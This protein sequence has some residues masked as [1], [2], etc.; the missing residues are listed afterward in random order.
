MKINALSKIVAATLLALTLNGCA[1]LN[2]LGA[3]VAN[4]AGKAGDAVKGIFTP[5]EKK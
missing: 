5:S 4:T 2:D 1:T 3:S